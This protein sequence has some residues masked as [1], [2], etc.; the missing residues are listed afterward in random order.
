MHLT[1][2]SAKPNITIQVARVRFAVRV[3]AGA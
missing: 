3:K 2:M 1:G